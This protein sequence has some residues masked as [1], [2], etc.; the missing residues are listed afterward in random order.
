MF[1]ARIL[2]TRSRQQCLQQSKDP[3]KT[4]RARLLEE[5]YCA[6]GDITVNLDSCECYC[7]ELPAKALPGLIFHT[8]VRRCFFL[9]LVLAF[10]KINYIWLGFLVFSIRSANVTSKDDKR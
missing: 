8:S 6:L 5:S 1:K 9:L 10:E 7:S 3:S 2:A 4:F